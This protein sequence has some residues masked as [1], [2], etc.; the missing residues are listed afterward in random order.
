MLFLNIYTKKNPKKTHVFCEDFSFY[1][2]KF[3]NKTFTSIL[4]IFFIFFATTSR[5]EAPS[6]ARAPTL[7]AKK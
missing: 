1:F 4:W 5:C 7:G 3:Q 6:V 2:A